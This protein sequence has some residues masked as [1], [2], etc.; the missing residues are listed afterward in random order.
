MK[1]RA[2]QAAAGPG[3]AWRV[4]ACGLIVLAA[5]LAYH[6]SFAVPFIFDDTT[7]ITDNPTIRHFWPPWALL[8]WPDGDTTVGARPLAN[9]TL[10]LNYALSGTGVWSYHVLN[11]GVHVLAG[12]TLLGVVRRTL[13]G[14]SLAGRFAADAG[15]IA[16]FTALLWTLHPLQTE[17]VTYVIQRVES[18]MGLFLLLSLYCFIRSVGSAREAAWK[19]AAVVLCLAGD[20]T[21][22]VMATAPLLILLYD[23]TFVAG[24]F[25]GA[26]RRG[27][28]FYG[29]L[30]LTWLPLG[31]LAASSG[32]N[33]RGSAGFG[34]GA[35]ALEYWKSQFEAVGRYLGLSLW[36]SPLV[37]EYGPFRA[38]AARAFL[39]FALVIVP[40]LCWVL[41]ALWRR[42]A[43]GF[44]GA[45]FFL[46]LAPSSVVPVV[47]QTMAEHRMYLP[48]AAV[49]CAAVIGLRA[50]LPRAAWALLGLTAVCLGAAT[51][52][53]NSVYHSDLSIWQDTIAKR[54]ANMNAR[55]NYGLA[56]FRAGRTDEAVAQYQAALAIEPNYPGVHSNLG[57]ALHREGRV[58][59]AIA[60]YRR[61]I[62]LEPSY[63]AAHY[64]LAG[65]LEG[66]GR[67]EE[68][69]GEYRETVRLAPG[70]G[71][72]HD[73]LGD[74][75]MVVG[76]H[77]EAA[78]EFRAAVGIDA[79]DARA[80][81]G[82]GAALAGG[83]SVDD[84][85]ANYTEAIRRDPNQVEARDALGLLLCG[86]GR[87]P[88]GILQFEE[89]LRAKPGFA[90][91]HFDLANALV[92]AGRIPEAVMHLES[93]LRADPNLAEASN[94]LGIILCRSGRVDE[95]IARIR[96]AI[97]A[98]PGLAQAHFA[99]GTALL[100]GG[101]RD[102]AEAEYKKV[103][104]LRP[105][106]PSA[107]RMLK[108][109]GD[110]R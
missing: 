77:D 24:S 44:L 90:K 98:E 17:S 72:G 42:P 94:N 21:K 48:L 62:E 71:E 4:A 18:L 1:S 5:L 29:A 85:I 35:P 34:S 37:F 73:A 36:P 54:P 61:A 101:H 13:S 51:E 79:A 45:W 104:E 14:P 28:R 88:E 87:G 81:A 68:A 10:G 95:G 56:L 57:N 102:E 89:A 58:A 80:H 105:G 31:L 26:L 69:I 66:A 67:T 20:A 40:V 9:A 22:E 109:I 65:A 103:L 63:P 50:L 96:D 7:A 93:A 91:A 83:G 100:Q 75:L 110:A 41:W 39:P 59:E 23:R 46:I 82:L 6:N 97:R 19:A 11:L 30:A 2:P 108:M 52:A 12:L 86:A 92:Q 76:R 25:R 55:N 64:N 47:T 53:R 27:A 16:F 60:H 3:T 32:W 43:A 15:T 49:I 33:R 70:F 74:A 99:L 107:D 8:T 78:E 84:A 106:D 38:E